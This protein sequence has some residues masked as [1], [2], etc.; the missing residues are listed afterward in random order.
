MA[1]L[2]DRDYLPK[3]KVDIN[4]KDQLFN[5][6]R[7][8]LAERKIGFT[9]TVAPDEGYDVVNVLTNSL[10]SIDGNHGTLDQAHQRFQ[11]F[12][13]FGRGLLT[14]MTMEPRR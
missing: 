1:G 3:P 5:D 12:L 2:T 8:L 14:T 11:V 9:R 13:Q 6:V 7:G 10:W 4:R